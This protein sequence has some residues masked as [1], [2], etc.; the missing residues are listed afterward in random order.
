M[1]LNGMFSQPYS[2]YPARA[3]AIGRAV[4]LLFLF[5]YTTFCLNFFLHKRAQNLPVW[6]NLAL[7]RSKWTEMFYLF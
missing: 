1:V 6:N 5:T 4:Y 3:Q 7:I 2:Q